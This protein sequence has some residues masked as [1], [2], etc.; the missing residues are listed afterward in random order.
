MQKSE[1]NYPML[2]P[3]RDSLR[4]ARRAQRLG[5]LFAQAPNCVGCHALR[6]LAGVRA[7]C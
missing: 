2:L 5:T 6:Q 3:A 7:K 4:V 1:E